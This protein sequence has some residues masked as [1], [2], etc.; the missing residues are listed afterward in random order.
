MPAFPSCF[1]FTAFVDRNFFI[2]S[3]LIESFVHYTSATVS[4]CDWLSVL[5]LCITENTRQ[6]GRLIY[7]VVVDDMDNVESFLSE[8][9][10]NPRWHLVIQFVAGLIGD[11]MRELKE[12]RST[13]ER[14]R[15]IFV[16]VRSLQLKFSPALTKNCVHPGA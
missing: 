16:F 13:T 8:H 14:Y 3:V 6:I 4:S 7:I 11:K 5:F 2:R 15:F 12:E 1:L 10:H 9:I